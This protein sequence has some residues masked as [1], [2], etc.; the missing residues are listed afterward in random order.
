MKQVKKQLIKAILKNKVFVVCMFLMSGM[1]SFMYFFVH[2]SIDGNVKRLEAKKFLT[3][4]ERAYWQGL[5]AN[6]SLAR[7]MLIGFTILTLLVYGLFYYRFYKSQKRTLG[8][9]KQLGYTDKNL[10]SVFYKC[11]S[12]VHFVGVLIG[13]LGGYFGSELLIKANQES[14]LVVDVVK[15]LQFKTL[16]LGIGVPL[17]GILL[18]TRWMYTMIQGKET[19]ILISGIEKERT[20]S[21]L[22]R[23]A[24]RVSL[25]FPKKYQLPIRL[26][27]RQ[28][29][30]ALLIWIS[31]M[32]VSVLFILA[33]SLNMSSR[34]LVASQVMGREY[35]Y[36]ITFDKPQFTIDDKAT[37]LATSGVVQTN[38]EPLEWQV[39]G[40]NI[41]MPLFQ[42][43]NDAQ[44]KIENPKE[45]EVIIPKQ[46]QEIYKVQKGDTLSLQI[47][48]QSLD[49]QVKEIAYNGEVGHV[50]MNKDT[51]AQVLGLPKEAYTGI[52]SMENIKMPES[53]VITK[54]QRLEALEREQVSNRVSA[55]INQV[56]GVIMGLMLLF[57]ALLLN[58]QS[59][60]K[61]IL[62]LKGLGYENKRIRGMLINIYGP[63]IVIAYGVTLWPAIQVVKG[64]L[65]SLSIQI[66][67]YMM[68]QTNVYV[69]IGCLILLGLL[70][71][72]VQFLFQFGINR[73]TK[74]ENA[75]WQY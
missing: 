34:S 2:Y 6:I 72:M 35:L 12:G 29:I 60:R 42:L 74:K 18:V 49:C 39:L 1:T 47:G 23:F 71:Y 10:K 11:A 44:Q 66:G 61:E 45:N 40:M 30:A 56:I 63:M 17:I 52:L 19:G 33:Y 51:L 46:L 41:E 24:N 54:A 37:Y 53:K 75:Q 59:C 8:C 25:C 65:R 48:E 28:P 50:Y 38:V 57:L 21:K 27:L 7:S 58:L 67:D 69:V 68:F 64:I 15:A 31:V 16:V 32:M 73:M 5:N 55:V 62:I 70:Y 13:L 4:G 22:L 43:V 9:M 14:Y 36:D 26:A 3:E 20:F